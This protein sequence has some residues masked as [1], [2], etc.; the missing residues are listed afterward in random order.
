MDPQNGLNRPTQ[1]VSVV[2]TI[3]DSAELLPR[4]VDEV[5]ST[6]ASK[7]SGAYLHELILVNDGSSDQ[8]LSVLRSLRREFDCIRIVNL[9]RNFGHHAAIM[10]GLEKCSGDLVFLLD[11]DLEEDPAWFHDF[12]ESMSETGA[13]VVFGVQ[14]ERRG[15]GSRL[16][17]LFGHLL[18]RFLQLLVDYRIPA[19]QVTCR[20]MNRRFV[21]TAVATADRVVMLGE[22]WAWVG[23]EQV[24]HEVLKRAP[25]GDRRTAYSFKRRLK[26]AV[27]AVSSTSAAPLAW[28]FTVGIA[29]AGLSLFV[30]IGTIFWRLRGGLAEGTG[31]ATLL[32]SIWFLGGLVVAA[33]GLTGLYLSRVFE[34]IRRRPL[35]VVAD[36]E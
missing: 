9:S 3:F 24:P 36:L 5:V 28:V 34:Q 4:F 7:N 17:R 25:F 15:S 16:H 29:V 32:L 8:S 6:F 1:S 12:H 35:Y 22:L 30:A 13:D 33:I 2:S 19:D 20:L 10:A 11:S 27:D 26:L 14:S 31:F 23:F 18:W 21:E